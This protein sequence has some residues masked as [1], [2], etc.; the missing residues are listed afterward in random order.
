MPRRPK[1]RI[2]KE[3]VLIGAAIALLAHVDT[4]YGQ[5]QQQCYQPEPQGPCG[6]TGHS[7]NGVVCGPG[8]PTCYYETYSAGLFFTCEP[9]ETGAS[10]C[11]LKKC[12]AVTQRWRCEGDIC[13]PDGD[14]TTEEV[15]FVTIAI[16]PICTQD[17][18]SNE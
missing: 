7:A 15:P 3:H 1:L 11:K 4:I 18:P 5:T 16:T 8:Q 12:Y 14:P 9:A 13:V 10:S 6:Q 2:G 17:P